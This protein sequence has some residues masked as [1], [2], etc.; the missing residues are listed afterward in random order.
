MAKSEWLA[1]NG[2][3]IALVVLGIGI[4]GLRT[5]YGWVLVAVGG[6]WWL[7]RLVWRHLPWEIR[8]KPSRNRQ[9]GFLT[10]RRDDGAESLR[11]MFRGPTDAA[12][13]SIGDVATHVANA[14]RGQGGLGGQAADLL[15]K[16]NNDLGSAHSVTLKSVETGAPLEEL[17]EKFVACFRAY[18]DLIDPIRDAGE[19]IGYD[20]AADGNYSLWKRND[21]AFLRG[22]EE[23]TLS[24][25]FT[26]LRAQVTV[27][28][29]PQGGR[30]EYWA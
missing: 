11:M 16:L 28:M 12:V 18:Q 22:L 30:R 26:E 8:R 3:P 9:R 1:A 21:E 4:V 27:H 5:G 13:R 23:L 15:Y 17:Q 24:S 10:A 25:A 2:G 6:A 14:V 29:W 7:G 20:W 19:E